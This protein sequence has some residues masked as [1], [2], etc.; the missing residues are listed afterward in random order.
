MS[1]DEFTKLY[2]FMSRRFD[3]IDAKLETKADKKDLDRI[4]GLLDNL[5]K[6]FEVV[7]GERLVM[8]HQLTRVHNWIER[9][10]DH[11]GVPF[12]T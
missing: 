9:A 4:V 2:R 1:T 3:E 5:T 11:I 10:A 12:T 8:S 6:R 7:E